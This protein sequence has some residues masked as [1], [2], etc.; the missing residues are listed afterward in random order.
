M[1]LNWGYMSDSSS[2]TKVYPSAHVNYFYDFTANKGIADSTFSGTSTTFR[3]EGLK[4][5]RSTYNAGVALNIAAKDSMYVTV[6][7]DLDLKKKY[8]SH[9]GALSLRYML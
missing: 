4:P 2:M 5:A 9:A 3:T 1:A 8:I 7:Y 6:E